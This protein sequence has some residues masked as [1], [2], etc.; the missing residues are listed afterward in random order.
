VYNGENFVGAAIDSILA[1]SYTDFELIIS[2]NASTDR[3][4]EICES[5]AMQD[6]R[7]HYRRLPANIGGAANF[8]R[9]LAL[10]RGEYFKWVAHDDLIA[11]DFLSRCVE[12]L[13]RDP[14]AVLSQSRSFEID[15][16]G[17]VVREIT[18]ELPNASS[19]IAAIRFA[20]LVL[21]DH[22]CLES[23]GVI[24]SST[25][26]QTPGIASY[27]ASDRV[28]LA[29]LGLRGRFCEV[30]ER[31]ASI[32]EHPQRAT[33]AIPFHQRALWF[34]PA[35]ASSVR[36]PHW[37]FY[38]EY[39]TRVHR[40]CGDPPER[41]RCYGVLCRWPWVNMNWARLIADLVIAVWPG[42]S[43]ALTSAG[44]RRGKARARQSR[45]TT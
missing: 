4:R 7:I 32:R 34:D 37:R 1:Q 25:L 20:D 44:R 38:K 45:A 36:F 14:S 40:T 35:N 22:A 33:R 28:M 16:S 21:I 18:P 2:D 43:T 26:R 23:Y 10:A 13:D 39:F 19:P 24:R 17:C 27:I 12:A 6:R 15:E 5:R 8:N 41:W 29:E 9:V 42:A 3:T 31:L 30:T 11:P